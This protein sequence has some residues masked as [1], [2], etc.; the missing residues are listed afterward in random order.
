MRIEAVQPFNAKGREISPGEMVDLPDA[1]ALFRIE[2]AE[3]WPVLDLGPHRPALPAVGCSLR[4]AYRL[5]VMEYPG[6]KDGPEATGP[7]GHTGALYLFTYRQR[8]KF[9]GLQRPAAA[10]DTIKDRYERAVRG[11]I[12]AT[13]RHFF[14]RRLIDGELELRGVAEEDLTTGKATPVPAFLLKKNVSLVLGSDGELRLHREKSRSEP[15][16]SNLQVFEGPA[17]TKIDK[18]KAFKEAV[19]YIKKQ[20]DQSPDEKP[21]S[22]QRKFLREVMKKTGV[23]DKLARK[24][25]HKVVSDKKD[26]WLRRRGRPKNP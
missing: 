19:A 3:A 22:I 9:T 2:R 23:T 21:F 8:P 14:I 11:F 10:S 12:L 18:E 25:F 1:K 24:A 26:P 13:A 7:E 4:E 5:H 6:L 20:K 17:P 16:F 15:L